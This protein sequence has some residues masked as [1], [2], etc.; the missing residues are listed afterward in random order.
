MIGRIAA[1]L[2]LGVVMYDLSEDSLACYLSS[3]VW[4]RYTLRDV[5]ASVLSK[6]ITSFRKKYPA[7]VLPETD[8]L[9]FYLA[10]HA[11]W[12]LKKKYSDIQPLSEAAQKL[13]KNCA[14]VMSVVP[15]RVLSYLTLICVEEARYIP[16]ASQAVNFDNV[17]G[18]N[19]GVVFLEYAHNGFSKK[20]SRHDDVGLLDFGKEDMTL[21]QFLR[22]ITGVF[23]FGKWGGFGGFG[24]KAWGEIAR[25]THDALVG[26]ASL[27][28][29]ADHAFSLCH[30]NG[31]MFNKQKCY[32]M[33]TQ[34][35][36]T[37]LDVQ[38]SGQVPQWLA[39]GKGSE[40]V[41]KELAN[42]LS[43]FK[44]EFPAEFAKKLNT[45]LIS[46]SAKNRENKEQQQHKVWQ[47]QAAA[48]QEAEEEAALTPRLQAIDHAMIEVFKN[49]KWL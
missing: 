27:I 9:K 33:Y 13:A 45:S 12:M 43:F 31:S 36:Y 39:A 23:N 46:D 19:Y 25:T 14:E 30:N 15:M 18:G 47:Q 28:E 10:Q 49:K 38:A 29:M 17:L 34:Q 4:N 3:P 16:W 44:A 21:G 48:V 22:G 42:M 7:A 20:S 32:S 26:R 24:G 5:P 41:D 35:I 6:E 8:A 1:G 2:L 40:F 37:I 11:V